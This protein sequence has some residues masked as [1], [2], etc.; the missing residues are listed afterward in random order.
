MNFQK[1]LKQRKPLLTNAAI[2]SSALAITLLIGFAY[3]HFSQPAPD[4]FYRQYYTSGFDFRFQTEDNYLS[5]YKIGSRIDT[6]QLISGS[7]DRN[8][9]HQKGVLT[10]LA[11]VN[12]GC[13]YVMQSSDVNLSL[14]SALESSEMPVRFLPAIFSSVKPGTDLNSYVQTL[15]FNDFVVWNSE[16]KTPDLL[17]SMPT[18]GYILLDSEGIVLRIWFTSSSVES[19]RKRMSDQMISEIA[20]VKETIASL[21]SEESIAIE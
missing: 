17:T 4:E 13:P 6:K 5:R 20:I 10:L 8:L 9:E 1:Q 15:G 2:A 7:S 12:P 18:P 11:V 21:H 16:T 19:V 3:R 14:K